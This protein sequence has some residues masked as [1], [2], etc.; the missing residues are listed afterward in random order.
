MS[1]EIG[2]IF[3]MRLLMRCLLIGEVGGFKLGRLEHFTDCDMWKPASLGSSYV[4]SFSFVFCFFE[5]NRN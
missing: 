1:E 4:G 3:I 2:D 5:P